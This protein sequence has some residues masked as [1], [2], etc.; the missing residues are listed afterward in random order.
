MT[1]KERQNLEQSISL[2]DATV[3]VEIECAD[4]AARVFLDNLQK[5]KGNKRQAL[6]EIGRLILNLKTISDRCEV[7]ASCKSTL[8]HVL[9]KLGK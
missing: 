9:R 8:E 6:A 7:F 1:N 5:V 2:Y 4:E 3:S